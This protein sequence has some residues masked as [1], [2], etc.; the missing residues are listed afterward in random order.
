MERSQI[1]LCQIRCHMPSED[2]IAVHHHMQVIY[3]RGKILQILLKTYLVLFLPIPESVKEFLQALIL[4]KQCKQYSYLNAT[5]R[6]TGWW[7]VCS[8]PTSMTFT[9]LTA[10]L[11]DTMN[12]SMT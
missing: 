8:N 4:K 5:S 1:L 7:S 10:R 12:P 11:S 9:F 3:P 2:H 6:R